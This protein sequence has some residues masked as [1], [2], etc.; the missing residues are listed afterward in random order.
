MLGLM[1][2]LPVLHSQSESPEFDHDSLTELTVPSFANSV[3]FKV[4]PNAI[5]DKHN[6]AYKWFL[7]HG[8]RFREAKGI[9]V[10]TFGELERYAIESLAVGE[11]PKVYAVGPIIDVEGNRQF[12]FQFQSQSSKRSYYKKWLDEQPKGSVVLLCFGSRGGLTNPMQVREVA[13]GLEKSGHRFL[14]V[15]RRAHPAVGGDRAEEVE[16]GLPEGFEGRVEGRGMV[17]EWVDQVGV[18]GHRAIGGFV[19]HCGWN[20]IL[21][22]LW[23]GV[24]IATWPMYAE[25]QLNA[26]YMVREKGLAVEMRLD[27]RLGG[28]GL[29]TAEEV[30]RG[31]NEVM[32]KEN[33]VRRRVEEMSKRSREAVGEGGSSLASLRQ[34]VHDLLNNYKV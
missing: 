19:S 28:G 7:H 20:S 12:Q 15:L 14:W 11:T 10:N 32:E 23:F 16:E 21:E 33:E 27:Y 8:R 18:L 2:H 6:E 3:P 25:Q 29:V 1:L 31:V 24:P 22:S 17:C 26:F 5:L 30:E 4:L 34:F 13:A 9:L